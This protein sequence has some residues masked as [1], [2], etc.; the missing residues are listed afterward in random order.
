MNDAFV[1]RG[2]ERLGDLPGD[3]ERFVEWKTSAPNPL[4]ERRARHELHHE[5]AMAFGFLQSVNRG[6]IG[7]VERRERLCLAR[8]SRHAIGISSESVW[9]QLERDGATELRVSGLI[10]ITHST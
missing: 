3:G 10:D 6:N 1:V 8:E 4:R 7:V 9:K 5:E 2:L